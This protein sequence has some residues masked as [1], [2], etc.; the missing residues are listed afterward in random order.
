MFKPFLQA[1]ALHRPPPLGAV[2]DK[3]LRLHAATDP[4]RRGVERFVRQVYAA[5]FGADLRSFAPVLVSLRDGADIVAAAGYRPA[6]QGP[7]FL[8]RYLPGPVEALLAPHHETPPERGRIVEVG[9]L[10]AGRPGEGRRLIRLLGPHLEALGFD[11]V[12]ST[13]TEELR[14]LFQ[15]LGVEPIALGAA[16]AA[17]LGPEAALWGRYYDHRPAVLAGRLGLALQR[18]RQRA[19]GKGRA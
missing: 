18:M 1:D 12:V 15:R 5:R 11:W 10:A 2:P 3:A 4:D 6:A 7:L 9:H 8:E 14:H 16:D 13:L 17:L 19:D